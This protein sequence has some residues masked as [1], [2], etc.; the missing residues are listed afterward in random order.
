L[1]KGRI[2]GAIVIRTSDPLHAMFEIP[3]HGE[4]R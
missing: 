4:I 2:Q 1:K 3:V